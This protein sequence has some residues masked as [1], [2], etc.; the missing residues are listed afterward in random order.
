MRRTLLIMAV[1]VAVTSARTF[2]HT[3][4][5]MGLSVK[6]ASYNVGAAE[7]SQ[8]GLRFAWGNFPPRNRLPLKTINTER[9]KPNGVLT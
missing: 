9:V 3:A 5:D 1:V 6:W 7:S 8:L 4:V 2:A